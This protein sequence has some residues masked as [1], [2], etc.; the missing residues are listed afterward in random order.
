MKEYKVGDKI[1]LKVEV[2]DTAKNLGF[3]EIEVYVSGEKNTS[4]KYRRS[5]SQSSKA[6]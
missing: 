5:S 2:T 6:R 1:T 3:D 4:I